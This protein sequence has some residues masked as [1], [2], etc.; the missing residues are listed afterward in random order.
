MIK[1][2][3]EETLHFIGLLWQRHWSLEHLKHPSFVSY[4]NSAV[5]FS[6]RH[7]ALEL[8]HAPFRLQVTRGQDGYK[9]TRALEPLDKRLVENIVARQLDV[10]PN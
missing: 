4:V 2:V 6:S 7:E 8:T 3:T 9:N 5:A 10:A 1:V